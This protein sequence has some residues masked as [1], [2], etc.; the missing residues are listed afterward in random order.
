M[1]LFLFA[2]VVLLKQISVSCKILEVLKCTMFRLIE[3]RT[4][5]PLKHMKQIQDNKQLSSQ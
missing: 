2:C 1:L 4:S 3:S 5:F